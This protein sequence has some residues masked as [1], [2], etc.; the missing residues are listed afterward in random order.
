MPKSFRI[1]ALRSGL[2]FKL[3]ENMPVIAL[4]KSGFESVVTEESAIRKSKKVARFARAAASAAPQTID[5]SAN[6][7]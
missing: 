2:N 5:L 1:A 4:K 6:K 7:R 3:V